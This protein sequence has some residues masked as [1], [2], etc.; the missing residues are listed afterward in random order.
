MRIPFLFFPSSIHASL[1]TVRI[2]NTFSLFHFDVMN[3]SLLDSTLTKKHTTWMYSSVYF[4]LTGASPWDWQLYMA[5]C[6]GWQQHTMFLMKIVLKLQCVLKNNVFFFC[7]LVATFQIQVHIQNLRVLFLWMRA[8][9]V[10]SDSDRFMAWI[11]NPWGVKIIQCSYEVAI[12]YI[13]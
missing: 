8:I 3:D 7:C 9:I 4:I 12:S 11:L 1:H 5:L 2:L 10:D 6:Q 13:P